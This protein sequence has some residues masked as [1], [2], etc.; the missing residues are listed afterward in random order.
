[1]AKVEIISEEEKD[2]E[3]R[4]TRINKK[5]EADENGRAVSFLLLVT[6]LL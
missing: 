3:P 6:V 2:D 4:R 5:E 1:M